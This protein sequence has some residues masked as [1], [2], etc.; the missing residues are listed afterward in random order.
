MNLIILVEAGDKEYT[1]SVAAL[2]FDFSFVDTKYREELRRTISKMIEEFDIDY[3]KHYFDDE[4]PY[5][6]MIMKENNERELDCI[7]CNENY[8][9]IAKYETNRYWLYEWQRLN[10]N[11]INHRLHY[12]KKNGES[13][14]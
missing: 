14:L 6:G 7:K 1:S 11:R 12:E 9:T 10:E 2:E 3:L 8:D 4:C 5:C 13:N